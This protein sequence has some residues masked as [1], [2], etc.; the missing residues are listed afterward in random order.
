ML[1][2]DVNDTQSVALACPRA[3]VCAVETSRRSRIVKS[4]RNK[5]GLLP[6]VANTMNL[7]VFNVVIA[8]VRLQQNNQLCKQDHI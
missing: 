7:H 6:Q 2:P 8:A 3:R 5:K 1:P 4:L